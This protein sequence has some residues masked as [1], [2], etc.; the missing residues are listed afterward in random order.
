MLLSWDYFDHEK[1]FLRGE[2]EDRLKCLQ[3]FDGE[4]GA[5]GKVDSIS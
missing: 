2:E 4:S 5:D 3:N 1:H